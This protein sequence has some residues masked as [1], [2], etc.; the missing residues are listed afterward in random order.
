V[1]PRRPIQIGYFNQIP[2]G[3]LFFIVLWFLDGYQLY[4]QCCK[5]WKLLNG[6]FLE[7][8]APYTP[9]PL[10]CSA[11]GRINHVADAAYAADLALMGASHFTVPRPFFENTPILGASRI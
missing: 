1:H 4:F 5:V 8:F 9:L 6:S 11:Q 3:F 7:T 2:C 10:S